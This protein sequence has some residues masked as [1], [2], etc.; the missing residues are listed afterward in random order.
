MGR[1][2]E[3]RQNLART[4]GTISE[5]SKMEAGDKLGIKNQCLP[6]CHDKKPCPAL[7]ETEISTVHD[8]PPNAKA[9]RGEHVDY[10]V[11]EDRMT[12][13]EPGGLL[14]SDYSGL[15]LFK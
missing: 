13:D 15:S 14:K 8:L 10:S 6:R 5:H 12:T 1:F 11:E 2:W 3:R 7:W 9:P 4:V